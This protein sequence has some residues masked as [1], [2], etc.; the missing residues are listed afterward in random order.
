MPDVYA[1]PAGAGVVR[2]C[3]DERPCQLLG[4]VLSP[5]PPKPGVTQKEHQQ[6]VRNGVCNGVLAY[7][8]SAQN[9]ENIAR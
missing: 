1:Q 9:S 6:Y 3:F 2:P 7:K 5:L 8:G 4:Q